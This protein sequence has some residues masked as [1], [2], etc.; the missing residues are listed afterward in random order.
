MK[1]L[2]FLAAISLLGGSL[3]FAQQTLVM[4]GGQ[5]IHGRYDG[6]NSD[7]IIF[8]DDHGNRHRFNI[9]EV[10]NLIFGG[11]GPASVPT[12]DRLS[13]PPPPPPPPG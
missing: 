9:S 8:I 3:A 6:G 1:K 4:N 13:P 7:T 10:Q 5:V 11:P 2:R 12:A